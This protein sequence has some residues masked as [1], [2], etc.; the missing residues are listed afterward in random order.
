MGLTKKV[1][2]MQQQQ[3]IKVILYCIAYGFYI[4]EMLKG[5]CG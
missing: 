5:W 4:P 2:L 1:E 3:V